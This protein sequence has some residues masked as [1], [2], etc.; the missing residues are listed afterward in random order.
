MKTNNKL[1]KIRV[2][3]PPD[4]Q[5]GVSLPEYIGKRWNGIYVNVEESGNSIILTS[6]SQPLIISKTELRL[7][8]KKIEV[9]II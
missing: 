6:G 5:Y 9:V 4:K 1:K 3:T 7:M 2:I 8:S